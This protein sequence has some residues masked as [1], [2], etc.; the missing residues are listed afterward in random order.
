MADWKSNES[1]Q[2]GET[3]HP[4][5]PP[6]AVVKPELRKSAAVAVPGMFYFLGPVAVMVL[7]AL[8]ALWFMNTREEADDRAVPTTGIEQEAPAHRATP[9]GGSTDP[10]HGSAESESEFRGGDKP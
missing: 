8:F 1:Q 2:R 4:D 7:V 9:G 5:N 3:V 6:N 10:Q